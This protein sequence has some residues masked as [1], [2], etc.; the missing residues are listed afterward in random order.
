MLVTFEG[1]DGCGKST[2]IE[3]LKEY[4]SKKGYSHHLFREPG[5]TEISEKIRSLLLHETKNMAPVTE[6]LLFSAA[7]SQ[8]VREK[9]IPLLQEN[10]IVILDRFYDSTTA[11]QGYGR[12]SVSLED[13]K[14]INRI[15]TKSTVPDVTF[16]LKISPAEAARRT[17]AAEKD[18]MENSGITFFEKVASGYDKLAENSR[19]YFTIDATKSQEIIHQDII[20]I[21]NSSFLKEL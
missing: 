12:E 3:L 5:G 10:E 18:R 8:L 2:Q 9:I 11:Y 7:R 20:E 17:S 4:L 1:I 16:Y 19:R 13:I 6:L 21:L 15:A 14:A